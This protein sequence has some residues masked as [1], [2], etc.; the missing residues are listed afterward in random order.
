VALAS[1]HDVTL[2]IGKNEQEAKL[3][4]KML[5]TF[6]S[7][8]PFT[9]TGTK[10]DKV[11]NSLILK[12]DNFYYVPFSTIT[13]CQYAMSREKG[14]KFITCFLSNVNA[15]QVLKITF[16][17]LL[18][19]ELKD[20]QI[21]SSINQQILKVAS[22]RKTEI[23]N[24][25][26]EVLSHANNAIYY[27]EEIENKKK[28]REQVVREKQEALGQLKVELRTL[29]EELT[30]LR[31]EYAKKSESNATTKTTIT[32]LYE[33]KTTIIE[34]IAYLKVLLNDLSIEKSKITEK[35]NY[36]AQKTED[37]KLIK[38]WLQGAV[39]HRVVNMKEKEGLVV[40]IDNATP[41]FDDF[42]KSVNDYFHPQ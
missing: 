14:A 32:T 15:T 26:Q 38:Y 23:T 22:Q 17:N 28:E 42:V 39:Y 33:T 29:N 6:A 24:Y 10:N 36:E 18:G 41:K 19:N 12:R 27:L 40:L 20:I 1:S 30:R 31:Q 8:I 7:G 34:R 11:T 4:M 2:S 16:K 13:N 9:I 35:I 5:E 37:K 3:D 25:Y 21:P